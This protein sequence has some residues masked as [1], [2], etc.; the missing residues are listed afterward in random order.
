M[1]HALA[2]EVMVEVVVILTVILWDGGDFGFD[3]IAGGVCHIPVVR[4]GS[5]GG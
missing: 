1:L 2:V 4:G 5:S 3:G